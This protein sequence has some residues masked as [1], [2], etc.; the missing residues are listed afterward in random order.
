[1][2]YSVETLPRM[3]AEIKKKAGLYTNNTFRGENDFKK[4]PTVNGVPIGSNN[5]FRHASLAN[6][7]QAM[8]RNLEGDNMLPTADYAGRIR[9][10]QTPITLI[11]DDDGY[12]VKNMPYVRELVANPDKWALFNFDYSGHVDHSRRIS[13]VEYLGTIGS[14]KDCCRIYTNSSVTAS[15]GNRMG[16]FAWNANGIYIKLDNRPF[17]RNTGSWNYSYTQAAGAAWRNSIDGNYYALVSGYNKSLEGPLRFSVKLFTTDDYINGTW[18]AVNGLAAGCEIRSLVPAPYTGMAPVMGISKMPGKDGI[19]FSVLQLYSSTVPGGVGM[20]IWD[21]TFTY[22]RII[23]LN[24]DIV[25]DSISWMSSC[26]YKGKFMMSFG[27]GASSHNTGKRRVFAADNME[28]PYIEHSFV[29]DFAEVGML[30]AGSL[31]SQSI[32]NGSLFVYNDSLYYI[33]SGSSNDLLSG[34]AS[35]HEAF[36]WQYND[37]TN[38]W[39]LVSAP[40]MMA[41]H[42]LGT[43]EFDE[44]NSWAWDHMGPVNPHFIENGKLYFGIEFCSGT[45]SYEGTVGYIDLNEALK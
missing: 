44:S 23:E 21:E 13:S 42:G 29:C 2:K 40:I 32:A 5:I 3:D 16:I 11:S 41:P 30:Q 25:L 43:W 14:D 1:M 22:K 28:G 18:T 38:D 9:P 34:V 8:Y 4:P 24:I 10:I 37:S 39:N 20:L 6:M 33:S 19:Y 17:P 31:F 12:L 15:A 7:K 36:L 45:D 27:N 35:N 26:Y